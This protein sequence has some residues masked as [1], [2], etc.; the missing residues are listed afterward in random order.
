M[1]AIPWDEIGSIVGRSPAAARQ[2]AD[3][4]RLRQLDVAIL[5]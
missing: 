4:E 3:R 2:L 5:E 1:F